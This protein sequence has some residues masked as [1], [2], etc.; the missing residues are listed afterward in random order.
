M[1]VKTNLAAGEANGSPHG[2]SFDAGNK[3]A[4]TGSSGAA[5]GATTGGASQDKSK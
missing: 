3:S 2:Q 1:S 4:S 5:S